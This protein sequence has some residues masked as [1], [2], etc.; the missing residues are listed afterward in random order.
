MYRSWRSTTKRQSSQCL[1]YLSSVP[2]SY[3]SCSNAPILP[4]QTTKARKESVSKY[5]QKL[6]T[7][8]DYLIASPPTK[9]LAL[10]VT[11]RISKEEENSLEKT[12]ILIQS[13]A[14]TGKSGKLS[15][16]IS[17]SNSCLDWHLLHFC[18]LYSSTKRAVPLTQLLMQAWLQPNGL[19]VCQFSL[20]L[21]LLP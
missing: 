17:S 20:L 12:N 16:R 9:R 18:Q 5:S 6:T 21:P 15:L 2:K 14:P 1:Q 8:K 4:S 11:S 13:S 3:R 7:I 10:S 19:K